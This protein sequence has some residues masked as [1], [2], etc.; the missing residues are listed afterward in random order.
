MLPHNDGHFKGV[1][2]AHA[3]LCIYLV[4]LLA[5]LNILIR[6]LISLYNLRPKRDDYIIFY[7]EK[8]K[9]SSYTFTSAIL[10]QKLMVSCILLQLSHW[11]LGNKICTPV[12]QISNTLYSN[13]VSDLDIY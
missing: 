9:M 3:V 12:S 2:C 5:T 7:D 11:N 4:F 1:T 13:L 8:S 6:T 10:A